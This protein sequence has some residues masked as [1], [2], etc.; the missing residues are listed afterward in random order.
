[1][2]VTE[3]ILAKA[4]RLCQPMDFKSLT[5]KIQMFVISKKKISRNSKALPMDFLLFVISIS[6]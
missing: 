5:K 4:S 2:E 6:G 3:I 1:M